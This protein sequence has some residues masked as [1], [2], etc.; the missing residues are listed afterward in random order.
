MI[1][2]N[3]NTII[4][5]HPLNEVI[6]VCLRLEHLFQQIDH[7]LVDATVL[8]TRNLIQSIA[9]TLHVLD[10]PDLKSKLA[11]EMNY[12]LSTLLR[13]GDTPE[14]D[15]DR[16]NHLTQQ[17]ETLS[18]NLIDSNVKI[19]HRL[20]DLELFNILRLQ[21]A[22]PGGACSFD[23]PLYSYW[24]EQPADT[25]LNIIKNW[26]EDFEQI[27]SATSLVLDLVR[28]HAKIEQKTAVHGFHQ[29]LLDP[30][31]PLRMIRVGI[32]KDIAAYPEI[33]IG[34]HFLSIRFF[35]PDIEKRPGQFTENL[36]FWL[37]YCSA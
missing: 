4:Y 37:A 10:R 21:L 34:R 12:H 32:I 8:G 19:G 23:V 30:Q 25:R 2:M 5:D 16:L 7:Q 36:P 13:Y 3:D 26:L 17:L 18:R 11:K 15:I 27:R 31:S 24:L 22:S 1:Q 35:S 9:D 20:R 14:V 29:E 6:R 33:S 28:K